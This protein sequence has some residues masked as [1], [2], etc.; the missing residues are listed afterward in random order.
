MYVCSMYVCIYVCMYVCMYVVCIFMYMC[1]CM[2]VCVFIYVCVYVRSH[3]C[4]CTSMCVCMY[5]CMYVIYNM[6]VTLQGLS[7]HSQFPYELYVSSR[8]Y[9]AC[10]NFHCISRDEFWC[11]VFTVRVDKIESSS[12]FTGN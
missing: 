4:V 12:Y 6:S 7:E 10:I 1:G 11:L 8:L 9:E 2:Y 3:V 5:V